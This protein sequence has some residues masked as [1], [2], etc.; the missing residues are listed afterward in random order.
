M[1]HN[2][3]VKKGRPDGQKN[4]TEHKHLG[5][6]PCQALPV[7]TSAKV[8]NQ[9]H[10][11]SCPSRIETRGS[12]GDDRLTAPIRPARKPHVA[13]IIMN[14]DSRPPTE[15]DIRTATEARGMALVAFGGISKAELL[16]EEH[17]AMVG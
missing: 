17:A 8:G 16:R 7:A 10:G 4:P 9:L 1:I 2:I 6:P 15:G 5:S 14:D 11:N 3:R 12:Q 13:N